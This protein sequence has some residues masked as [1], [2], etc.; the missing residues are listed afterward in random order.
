MKVVQPVTNH[1]SVVALHA[2]A[3]YEHRVGR[4]GIQIKDTEAR[5]LQVQVAVLRN[6]N[7][8]RR[9]KRADDTR[10]GRICDIHDLSLSGGETVDRI[11]VMP[12]DFHVKTRDAVDIGDFKRV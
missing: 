9:R 3:P 7:I 5:T 6:K 2:G 11:K 4:V 12:P 1:S 10:I 8:V